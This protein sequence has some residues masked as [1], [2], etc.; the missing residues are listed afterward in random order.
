MVGVGG[1]LAE[2]IADVAIRL[3]PI[4]RSTPAE[5]I[6]DLATQA[7]LGAVPRRA[8]R[9]PRRPRRRAGRALRRGRGPSA[10]SCR[11]TSTR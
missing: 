8:G 9:R 4:T 3:V 1:I 6:D 10:R 2:A 11:P 5:M 7:L